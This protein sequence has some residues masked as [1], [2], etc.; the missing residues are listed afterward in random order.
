MELFQ[1]VTAVPTTV[2]TTPQ[3]PPPPTGPL[4]PT[5]GLPP[6][7]EEIRVDQNPT[8]DKWKIVPMFKDD[9]A[10]RLM[11]WQVGFD[12]ERNLEMYHGYVHG[13]PRTDVTE[14]IPVGGKTLQAQALQEARQRY[15]IKFRNEGYRPAGVPGPVDPDPMLANM[16]VSHATYQEAQRQFEI[17]HKA[18]GSPKGAARTAIKN[19]FFNAKWKLIERYPVATQAKLDGHR[20]M[21][22]LAGDKV[23]CR[24]PRSNRLYPNTRYQEA[25]LLPLFSYLPPGTQTDGELYHPDWSF[26]QLSSVVKTEVRLH[27]KMKE[28]IYYIFDLVTPE[29]MPYEDRYALLLNAYKRYLEEDP[30]NRDPTKSL[31]HLVTFTL[32]YSD[33][34][35]EDFHNQYVQMGYEG[36]MVR[37]IA[38]RN[39]TPQTIAESLYDSK[40]SNNLL[41]YKH[42]ED[43]EGIV[44]AVEEA[45]GTEAGTADVVVV[46]PR[47]NI[48]PMRSRGSFERRRL[49]LEHPEQILLKPFTYRHQPPLTEYGVPR[50]P[51]GI[52]IRDDVP[53]EK[54]GLDKAQFDRA[55]RLMAE[56]YPQ[57]LQ[58]VR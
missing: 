34:E 28:V 13:N 32:A 25:E 31:I 11:V 44:I 49:W 57:F 53:P 26:E 55:R 33:D 18:A 47:G 27:P 54:L 46:D 17:A 9:V 8:Q 48:V 36:L 10:G 16:W 50:F 30:I 29:P 40:R 41:K 21:C 24:K 20:M 23:V 52:G 35:V 14:V 58:Y 22:K 1:Q 51:V 4:P 56:K 3:G 45:H 12:G 39:R 2:P 43:E 7:M 19:R 6:D 37:K 15:T 5:G 42:F 38:G